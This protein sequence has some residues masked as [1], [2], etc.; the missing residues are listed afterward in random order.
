[1]VELCIDTVDG[2]CF[3]YKVSEDVKQKAIENFVHERNFMIKFNDIE[4]FHSARNILRL[5]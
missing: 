2:E 3:T 5:Y 1:M 4:F